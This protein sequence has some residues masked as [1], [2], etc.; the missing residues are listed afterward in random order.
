MYIFFS[1]CGIF[2]RV[3]K[4]ISKKLIN[5]NYS[6]IQFTCSFIS[7]E[8]LTKT[9][10]KSRTR[11]VC[12]YIVITSL[13]LSIFF[14]LIFSINPCYHTTRI[15]L[16][17]FNINYYKNAQT[18]PINISDIIFGIAGNI[19]TWDTRKHYIESWWHQNVTRGF[20][21]L[22][23]API[24]HLPWPPTS[25]P[26]RVSSDHKDVPYTIRMARVIQ[27]TFEA[28]NRNVRW[29]VMA[30]DDTIFFL[31]NLVDILKKY[32][33]EGYYYVGMNSEA[34]ISNTLFSFTMGFGGAGVALSY[35]LA[36]ALAKNLDVCLNKYRKLHGSDQIL[37]SC[38]SDFGV[39][40]TQE[41]GFHQIDLHG[42]ISGLLSAHPQTPLVSL[43]HLDAVEPLFPAMDRQQSL[44][45]L[46]KSA[47]TDQSRLLQQSICYHHPKN[48]S[49]SLS[50][51]Y[52]VHIYEKNIPSSFLQVPLQTFGEWRKGARPAFM[53]NTRGLSRDPCE[54][55][56]VF[57][58][59]SV[60]ESGGG[61]KRLEV[62]T[63]YVRRLPRRLPPC[64]VNGNHSA[65]YVEKILVISP[66][67]RLV[68]E[69]S[70]RECC[71]IIQ[72]EK[73]N[74]TTIKL[75]PC[76]KYEMIG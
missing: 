54:T 16:P 58:F 70:R 26:V 76:M 75:R 7:F 6:V 72:M 46:M 11:K 48:W 13:F 56:H 55:P 4:K 10:K 3:N 45:H 74:A 49:F 12:K 30:D 52:S 71:D 15:L 44:N 42:D 19:K 51:G 25:P 32:D 36:E 43:H 8:M 5:T 29:Y 34:V 73:G 59:D 35:P 63:T 47:K 50:W 40:I 27:E 69:G 66:V 64:L 33:H 57:Y 2:I 24:Q 28:E 65:D 23:E 14:I 60:E 53:V 20:L 1:S 61:G 18:T 67:K 39:S 41:K 17:N 38:V 31:E 22:D 37:Q 9:H 21:F 68:T 62:V